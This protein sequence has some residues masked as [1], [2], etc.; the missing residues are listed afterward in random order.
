MRLQ[1]SSSNNKVF[2]L[3]EFSEW[4]LSISDDRLG[5]PNDGEALIE[6]PND[7]LIKDFTNPL[8][9]I[10][11]STYPN[12]LDDLYDVNYLQ[13]RAILAPALEI[14]EMVNDY[15]I[16]LIL[17]EERVY[18]SSDSVCNADGDIDF[19]E[20]L[21]T[22]DFLNSIRCSGV[23]NHK[24]KFKVGV[25][26]MLLKNVDQSSG[27]CNETRLIITQLGN[28]VIEAKVK[29]GNNIRMKVFISRMVMTQLDSR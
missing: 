16:S 12:L 23:P 26:V 13:N 27:L 10:V 4:L 15:V 24:L 18:L 29:S 7:L 17:G 1:S 6:V 5:D 3:K 14:I 19:Q 21:H 2:E 28:H 22:P 9:A 25:L 11:E 20:N 8:A